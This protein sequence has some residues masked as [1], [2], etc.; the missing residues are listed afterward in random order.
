MGQS[1]QASSITTIYGSIIMA[2]KNT[3]NGDVITDE[4]KKNNSIVSLL[5]E[6]DGMYTLIMRNESRFQY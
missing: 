1:L 4:D 5:R 3:L 2:V 6:S